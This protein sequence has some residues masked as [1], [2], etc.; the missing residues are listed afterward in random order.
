[1]LNAKSFTAIFKDTNKQFKP[2]AT[3]SKNSKY[4]DEFKLECLDKIKSM[5]IAEVAEW[6]EWAGI[7]KTN[8][9]NFKSQH[10]RGMF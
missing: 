10:E 7:D 4:S 3:H 1:M 5:S 9:Y 8:I 2:K 6:A